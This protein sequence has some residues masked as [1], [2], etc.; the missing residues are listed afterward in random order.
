MASRHGIALL[1]ASAV[2]LLRLACV[3]S[4]ALR[5][6]SSR[7]VARGAGLWA[8]ALVAAFAACGG[9]EAPSQGSGGAGGDLF[10][11]A[12]PGSGGD[13]IGP[14]AACAKA[15]TTALLVPVNMFLIFDKS[16]SMLDGGKW[17]A[18]TKALAAFFQDPKV[19]GLRVALRFFPDNTCNAPQCDIQACTEPTVKIGKLTSEPAPADA[20]EQALVA[21]VEG[22]QPAGATPM[23]AALGGAEQAASIHLA[24]NP[25]HKAAVVL[26]TDGEPNGCE[27]DIDAIAAL[28]QQ[29][30]N[31]F[32]VTTYVVG[33]DGANEAQLDTIAAAGQTGSAFFIGQGDVEKALLEAFQAIQGKGLA[34]QFQLPDDETVDPGKVNVLH[35]SSQSAE[36]ALIGQVSGPEACSGDKDAWYY[37]DPSDPSAILLCPASCEKI[38]SDPDSKLEVV[39][40][41]ATEPAK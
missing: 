6:W 25:S 5:A 21:A 23:F 8:G 22:A 16:L 28:A 41:C 4:R 34:C 36:P 33:L 10:G 24:H 18:A 40:G 11:G 9:G 37:D 29:A 13:I 32:A 7:T 31:T 14:D 30:F 12:G 39:L 1:L 19:A 3:S 27:T 15:T 38:V 35:T 2:S 20:Q 26:V 17:A